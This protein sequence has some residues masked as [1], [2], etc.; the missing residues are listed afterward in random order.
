[1]PK[2]R[3]PP[4]PPLQLAIEGPSGAGKSAGA[5]EL[6]RRLG[7]PALPAA[8][9]RLGG[10]VTLEY[11]SRSELVELELRLLAEE[12]RRFSE[13]IDRRG[14]GECVVLDTGFL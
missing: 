12:S 6:A 13:A 8:F 10:R 7:S 9:E 1:M 2:T 3:D 5:R 4:V 11:N 14:R